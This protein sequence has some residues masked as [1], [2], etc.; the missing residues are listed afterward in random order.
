MF[1]MDA[2]FSIYYILCLFF[3]VYY[4]NNIF[5]FLSSLIVGV[6]LYVIIRMIISRKY[7]CQ[8]RIFIKG[9]LIPGYY[10]ANIKEE[11]S[12]RIFIKVYD[13]EPVD[14]TNDIILVSKDPLIAKILM[15]G[16]TI[17]IN[18]I[19]KKCIIFVKNR[20]KTLGKFEICVKPGKPHSVEIIK[21]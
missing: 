20:R 18:T 6:V 4:L 17:K 12:P 10:V 7:S 15:N 11:I 2:A 19:A 8:L 5:I 9:E 1:L 14:I 21:L 3:Y 13:K 16:K